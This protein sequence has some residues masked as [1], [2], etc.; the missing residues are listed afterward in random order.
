[1]APSRNSLIAAM[2]YTWT[3]TIIGHTL[4]HRSRASGSRVRRMIDFRFAG[5][6]AG[7]PARIARQLDLQKSR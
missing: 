2:S 1:M 4:L 6:R 5:S 7:S 3:P